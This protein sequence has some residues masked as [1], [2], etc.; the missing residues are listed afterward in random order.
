M[1]YR[2]VFIN[3]FNALQGTTI[4]AKNKDQALYIASKKL[5]LNI[6]ASCIEK[7]V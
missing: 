5:G 2:V 6:I 7:V 1:T 4:K 3:H